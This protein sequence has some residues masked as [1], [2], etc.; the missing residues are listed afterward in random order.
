MNWES[1]KKNFITSAT[2]N[3]YTKEEISKFL[4]YAENLGKKNLPIIFDTF[5]FSL[6]VGYHLSY[7]YSAA[8][9][10]DYFY[11]KF[12]IKKNSGGLREIAEPLPSLKEIQRWILRNILYKCKFNKYVKSYIPNMS[13]KDNARFHRNQK[14]VLSIDIKNFFPSIKIKK[15]FYFFENLGYS[16]SVSGLLSNLCCLNKSLPQ[17][18]P[19]SP[20]LSNLIFSKVDNRIIGFT[21]KEGI[22]YTRYS[23]DLTFSG[24]FKEGKI[25]K[26]RLFSL[27][28]G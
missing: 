28:S 19:T 18:S 13:I 3:N 24:E 23:D 25:I 16:N 11:R 22:R 1:Y 17:G 5:H 27:T 26:F 20:A 14:M 21:R 9:A 6:L 10:P 15:V 7:L 12:K 2:L 8:N 4:D